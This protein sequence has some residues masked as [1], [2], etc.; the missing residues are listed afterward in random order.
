LVSPRP[1][2][3]SHTHRTTQGSFCHGLKAFASKGAFL[4]QALLTN[5]DRLIIADALFE[6]RPIGLGA[7]LWR[8]P[9]SMKQAWGVT[10]ESSQSARLA[11]TLDQW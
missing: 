2:G 8:I 1:S 10:N 5:S 7:H 4:L 3:A 6:P 9:I 11:C